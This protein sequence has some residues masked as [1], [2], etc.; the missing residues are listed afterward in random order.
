M[1]QS[2]PF[3]VIPRFPVSR[4]FCI[5]LVAL[6]FVLSTACEPPVPAPTEESDRPTFAEGEA[7]AIVQTFGG[8]CP[9]KFDPFKQGS[10]ADTY[11]GN[12]QW[13]VAL[14]SPIGVTLSG[15]CLNK[16]VVSA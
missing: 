1:P 6:V 16:A 9:N 15:E 13:E 4:N 5:V 10:W 3:P 11:L 7:I 14:D 12:G 2:G 8:N